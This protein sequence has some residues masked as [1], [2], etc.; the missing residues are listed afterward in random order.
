MTRFDIEFSLRYAARLMERQSRFWHH[1]DATLRFAT[2]LSGSGAVASLVAQNTELSVFAML[3]FAALQALD[4][5]LQP[6]LKSAEAWASR[7]PYVVAMGMH[8]ATDEAL[9]AAWQAAIESD[10]VAGIDAIRRIAYN[11]VVEEKGCDASH[12]YTLTPWQRVIDI[13]A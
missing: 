9:Y 6:G 11:D 1:I 2:I 4:W 10:P 8:R 7:R 13:A 12:A 3:A 5:V